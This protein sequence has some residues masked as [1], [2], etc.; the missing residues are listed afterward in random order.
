MLIKVLMEHI[1]VTPIKLQSLQK[2]Y[3]SLIFLLALLHIKRGR[4]NKDK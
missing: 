4:D 2:K 1:E 3:P